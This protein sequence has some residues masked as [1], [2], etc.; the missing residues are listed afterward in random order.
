MCKNIFKELGYMNYK[1]KAFKK[2]FF[3]LFQI[4]LVEFEIS[5]FED[6]ALKKVEGFILYFKLNRESIENTNLKKY[7]FILLKS[8]NRRYYLRKLLKKL[9]QMLMWNFEMSI[10]LMG[11]LHHKY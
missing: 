2:L 10:P 4:G 11:I 1:I 3:A 7:V 9:L 8:L 6:I 5:C